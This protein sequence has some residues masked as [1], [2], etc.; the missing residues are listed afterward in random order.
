VS[1]VI[2][3]DADHDGFGDETQDQ[4]PT[5]ATTQGPC[6]TAA[7]ALSSFKVSN[8][9][10]SYSL[11]EAGT[12]KLT[13]SKATTGR[14][15]NGTCVRKTKHNASR[16]HCRRFVQVG[17]AFSGPGKVGA[18]SVALPKVHGRKLGP[19]RY[20]LAITTTDA[21]GNTKTITESF[22]IKPKPK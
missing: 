9:K 14:K 18:N 16:R 7:P 1:A 6:D 12:V 11:S 5:Q 22:R 19:G 10:A 20:Q 8:G 17:N 21:I 2:E 13:L 3:P 4:C 15:V